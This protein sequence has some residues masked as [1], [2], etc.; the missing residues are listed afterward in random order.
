MWEVQTFVQQSQEGH[1][2]QEQAATQTIVSQHHRSH[3]SYHG[4]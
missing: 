2:V 3:L 4:L 1:E